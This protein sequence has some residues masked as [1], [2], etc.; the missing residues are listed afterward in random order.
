[1]SDP[2]VGAPPAWAL[3][4][5]LR[6]LT[7]GHPSLRAQVLRLLERYPNEVLEA[8]P[9]RAVFRTALH[10]RAPWARGVGKLV[11]RRGLASYAPLL[12]ELLR[13]A[14]LRQHAEGWL[15][16]RTLVRPLQPLIELACDAE[17]GLPAREV[18]LKLLD[19]QPLLQPARL[20]PVLAAPELHPTLIAVLRPAVDGA[21]VDRAIEA[22]RAHGEA[23][24][25]ARRTR[26]RGSPHPTLFERLLGNAVSPL[27]VLAGLEREQRPFTEG[28]ARLAAVAGDPRL[29]EFSTW[30]T[31]SAVGEVLRAAW[32]EH[33]IQ[34]VAADLVR[35]PPTSYPGAHQATLAALIGDIPPRRN[36]RAR[37]W[38]KQLL[39]EVGRPASHTGRAAIVALGQLDDAKALAPLLEAA[40]NGLA[41][42]L[43][44]GEPGAAGHPTTFDACLRAAGHLG[45]A[46]F[47]DV[48]L[49]ALRSKE[50]AE[51]L[52]GLPEVLR[53]L[54]PLELTP[55]LETVLN[56]RPRRVGPWRLALE[57]VR[58]TG[59]RELLSLAA[60][61]A[62]GDLDLV[63]AAV[64][65]LLSPSLLELA[66]RLIE[67]LDDGPCDRLLERAVEVFG[68]KQALRLA[69]VVLRTG[70]GGAKA[71][72]R[73]LQLAVAGGG[74]VLAACC[75]LFRAEGASVRRAALDEALGQG[76]LT[77]VEVPE[78]HRYDLLCL[79]RDALEAGP[80]DRVAAAQVR[81]V[82]DVLLPP[83][84]QPG[85]DSEATE[86][87]RTRVRE[88]GLWREAASYHAL[89]R[90]LLDLGE[91]GVPVGLVHGALLALLASRRFRHP[92]TGVVGDYPGP[93]PRYAQTQAVLPARPAAEAHWIEEGLFD[94]VAGPGYLRPPRVVA[95]FLDA[96]SPRVRAGALELLDRP[97]LLA[98]AADVLDRLDDAD[99]GVR[100]AVIERLRTHELARFAANLTPALDDE[101][102]GVQLAA[103]R[104]LAAWGERESLPHLVRFLD[105][106]APEQRREAV[107]CLRGFA[108]D[109]LV[110]ALAPKVDL[111]QPLAAAGVL[112][113]LRPGRIPDDPL[114]RARLFE[115]AARG[116]GP[117]RAAAL[118]LLP[119]LVGDE[120]LREVVPLLR[121]AH[122]QVRQAAAAVL[123][124]PA[125]RKL[126]PAVAELARAAEG[127]ELRLELLGLLSDLDQ[128]EAA[129]GVL[130]LL[131]DDDP[132]VRGEVRAAI[133]SQHGY[134]LGPD[135]LEV[136]ERGLAGGGGPLAIAEL[137]HLLDAHVDEAAPFVSALGCEERPVWEA[138]LAA[139][140]RRRSSAHHPRLLQLLGKRL[141]PALT[142]LAIDEV[143][144]LAEAGEPLFA[145]ASKGASP[146]VRRK[147]LRALFAHSLPGD[148]IV[149]RLLAELE[150]G[151]RQQLK[152]HA[153]DA[154]HERSL[155][156]GRSR[157]RPPYALVQARATLG[158]CARL[159]LR[160][161]ASLRE[162]G[163]AAGALD[164]A[165]WRTNSTLRGELHARAADLVAQAPPRE[166]RSLALPP[167]AAL[168][169]VAWLARDRVD[170]KVFLIWLDELG[171]ERSQ[172]D[173]GY[174]ELRGVLAALRAGVVSR[175]VAG[176][177]VDTS[178]K[179]A[180]AKSLGLARWM[181]ATWERFLLVVAEHWDPRLADLLPHMVDNAA[182]ELSG[183]PTTGYGVRRRE[184][185]FS[186][187][188]RAT[189]RLEQRVPA[190]AFE[191]LCD[192]P[193]LLGRL[194]AA[195]N[196][197]S[198]LLQVLQ[199]AHGEQQ[200]D[201]RAEV[202]TLLGEVG[203][204]EVHDPIAAEVASSSRGVRAAAARALGLAGDA[205]RAREPLAALLGDGEPQVVE[206]AL[207]AVGL[208][209]DPAH[210]GA[211]RLHLSGDV[212]A[213]ALAACRAARTLPGDP[214]LRSELIAVIGR[215][216]DLVAPDPDPA[217]AA[218]RWPALAPA[219]SL[220][221]AV[222][223]RLLLLREAL[224]V[225]V[226]YGPLEDAGLRSALVD[227]CRGRQ[228]LDLT[229]AAVL[230]ETFP[231]GTLDEVGAL[232]GDEAP[233]TVLLALEALI[234][235]GHEPAF[236]AVGELLR[237]PRPAV[238]EAA[239]AAAAT[240]E[241]REHAEALRALLGD[242]EQP[243][244][245]R[246]AALLALAQLD[247]AEALPEVKRA[248]GLGDDAAGAAALRAAA[249]QAVPSVGADEEL[250][251]W[252]LQ[253]VAE[254]ALRRC[255]LPEPALDPEAA[256]R[257]FA[258]AL[259]SSSARPQNDEAQRAVGAAFAALLALD[260]DRVERGWA[261]RILLKCV[262]DSWRGPGLLGLLDPWLEALPAAE[263]RAWLD[264][265]AAHSPRHA[266]PVAARL[267]AEDPAAAARLLPQVRRRYGRS[268]R[269][270]HDRA[271]AV[272][273]ACAADPDA[274]Q[275]AARELLFSSESE[276]RL[277]ARAALGDPRWEVQP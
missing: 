73:A 237:D 168:D 225:L 187:Y 108:P 53:Q 81:A 82:L 32:R 139:L 224:E 254:N 256:E 92:L 266:A 155:R 65:E 250:A 242:A 200:A 88:V 79:V 176:R 16:E 265:Y 160:G 186:H 62:E 35:R 174:A 12:V 120:R 253:T 128:P 137:V 112:A 276:V 72:R 262:E 19:K 96:R 1:M 132:R 238:R 131:L 226:E 7:A 150:E 269:Q 42:A 52:P 273:L 74:D 143:E 157:Q 114:L 69:Q 36:R 208:L 40:L 118:R 5:L 25:A 28:V 191:Q 125:G 99:P 270:E 80:D 97:A 170:P 214:D 164:P 124:S 272:A 229:L 83:S 60:D 9:A 255:A 201:A 233:G 264:A 10:E 252:L 263:R 190:K 194:H 54:A 110:G 152:V 188:A 103:A 70:A 249:R 163:P 217:L 122:P 43:G 117:L 247:G 231:E 165:V 63:G 4:G 167:T 161:V 59:Q 245:V 203:A 105:S 116:A 29:A 213:A 232:L 75:A 196:T 13:T 93:L 135:L 136:L 121:D 271:V 127:A 64:A 169:H 57:T 218:N 111:G 101:D 30:A 197:A 66:T 239:C 235:R 78:A 86:V 243:P 222:K 6:G 274:W 216:R 204:P 58:L 192:S 260:A 257:A 94:L 51:T 206:Q 219:L 21:L 142:T 113:A 267:L 268:T 211:V 209:G 23:L 258:E 37:R 39:P 158:A 41:H 149:T 123:R 185:R 18:A 106:D 98:H 138:A 180:L 56:T 24:L 46:E 181:P 171:L 49:D 275:P 102:P 173:P 61:T 277:L 107:L 11:A 154:K 48:A 159:R 207:L 162:L 230:V 140:R 95:E 234:A 259:R 146:T 240:L 134:S 199:Q 67:R 100:R 31:D 55:T 153:A 109:D 223:P 3:P 236:A 85:L 178:G 27:G 144:A 193:A 68:E 148:K 129:R 76:L 14:E 184:E 246:A 228:R 33:G 261:L 147:A 220:A 71:Q 45:L 15:R 221:P 156:G 119:D 44:R 205:T 126:A 38:L 212:D 198:D 20:L 177:P 133:A 8:D 130:P 210:L 84:G 26:E 141:A 22:N 166:L 2:N 34:Q 87:L 183:V 251:R 115:V 175:L 77:R 179:G 215:C 17:A 227:A 202:V 151:A 89:H 195:Q 182:T 91:G 104:A 248:A 189:L 241:Q 50:V 145:L 172:S 47:S 90:D 244:G